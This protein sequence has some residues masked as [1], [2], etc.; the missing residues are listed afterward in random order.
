MTLI[1]I[2]CHMLHWYDQSRSCHLLL[3]LC[4][5]LLVLLRLVKILFSML[6]APIYNATDMRSRCW[7]SA[8]AGEPRLCKQSS[9]MVGYGFN[10]LVDQGGTIFSAR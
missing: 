7:P 4:L 10:A 5:G 2:Y 8:P 6:V 1:S 9:Q 3:K